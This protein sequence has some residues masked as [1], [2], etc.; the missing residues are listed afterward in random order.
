MK[1]L[2]LATRNNDKVNELR[3]LLADLDLDLL[4]PADIT[5]LGETVE[6]EETLEGNAGKKAREAFL[7]S[8]IPTLADDSGLEVYYLNNEPGVYSSRYAGPGATYEDNRKKLLGRLRGVPP[9]RRAAR[10]RCAIAFIPADSLIR[11]VEG[12]CPG[13]IAES[14]SGENGFGYDPIFLPTG[15]SQ[16]LAEME[17][18]L[19]NTLSHRAKA[20][21][22][23]RPVLQQL[24]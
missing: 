22:N 20:I 12:D 4:T 10:F 7:L 17:P 9:R 21:Q 13:V 19:K 14:P 8:R 2:L 15:Y 18:A 16:T 1:Q 24:L 11:T 5:G 23:I 3:A 6:D